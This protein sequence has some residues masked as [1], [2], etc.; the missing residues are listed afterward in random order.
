LVSLWVFFRAE[1]AQGSV[2]DAERVRY[3]WSGIGVCVEH[4][5]KSG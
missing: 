5:H 1:G 4:A 3:P 2:T